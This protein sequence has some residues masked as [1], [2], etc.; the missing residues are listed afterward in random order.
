MGKKKD[1]SV[2][3]PQPTKSVKVPA[4]AKPSKVVKAK[5]SRPPPAVASSS[6]KILTA[7]DLTAAQ[8]T[9][10]KKQCQRMYNHQ[11]SEQRVTKLETATEQ[12]EQMMAAKLKAM[13]KK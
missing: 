8:K 11:F 3:N 12:L 2:K 9:V 1:K 6:S 7:S 13:K 5:L 10:V 4:A